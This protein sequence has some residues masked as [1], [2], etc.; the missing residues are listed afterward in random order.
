[1]FLLA[2]CTPAH[3]QLL[4]DEIGTQPNG[5]Q[6]LLHIVS[7]CQCVKTSKQ[8]ALVLALQK[9]DISSTPG[10]D[11]PLDVVINLVL[12]KFGRSLSLHILN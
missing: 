6:V 4:L 1:M 12:L 9:L 7:N 2:S 11:V 3:R 5:L 10:E 8:R